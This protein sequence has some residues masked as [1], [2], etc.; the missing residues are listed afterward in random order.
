MRRVFAAVSQ[1]IAQSKSQHRHALLE[2]LN[3][4]GL[5]VE[6]AQC[7]AQGQSLQ[8]HFDLVYRD[9]WPGIR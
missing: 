2:S 1:N 7:T 3:I 5:A 6:D 9:P 8:V 4:R